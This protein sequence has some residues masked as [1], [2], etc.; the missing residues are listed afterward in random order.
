MS[1]VSDFGT[2]V[3]TD[4]LNFGLDN[5]NSREKWYKQVKAVALSESHSGEV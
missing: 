2:D 4:R 1:L 3:D 5:S